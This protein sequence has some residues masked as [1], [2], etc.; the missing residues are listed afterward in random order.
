MLRPTLAVTLAAAFLT[1][2]AGQKEAAA[3]AQPAPAPAPQPAPAPA[4]V[5]ATPPATPPPPPTDHAGEDAPRVSRTGLKI[6]FGIMPG[7]NDDDQDGVVVDD[8]FPG[9]SAA[10]A[11]IQRG[12]RL[13]T[14]NG[15][16]II[17]VGNWMEHMAPHKP[18]DVVD[19]GVLRGGKM[20]PI[21]VTLK[22]PE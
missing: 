11:G 7:N 2:C 19:I 20:V 12:D 18:G 13:M 14:W 17:D 22:G 15:K 5:A 8:V 3:P 4:P 16:T 21:K 1:A 10:D 9:T 6:R